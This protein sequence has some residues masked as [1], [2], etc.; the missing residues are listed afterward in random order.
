MLFVRMARKGC[1]ASPTPWMISRRRHQDDRVQGSVNT[2]SCPSATT[3]SFRTISIR[4]AL[5]VVRSIAFRTSFSVGGSC[6]KGLELDV[7]AAVVVGGSLATKVVGRYPNRVPQ[8][9]EWNN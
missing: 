9:A 3:D 2:R 4:V 6:R 5:T 7:I 1:C 8:M